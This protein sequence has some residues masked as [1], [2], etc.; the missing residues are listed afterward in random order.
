[1][2]S[3]DPEAFLLLLWSKR[4]FKATIS[5]SLDGQNLAVPVPR[6]EVEQCT[7]AGKVWSR[8]TLE[9]SLVVTCKDCCLHA[10]DPATTVQGR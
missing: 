1:M 9:N 8:S 10:Y 6:D 3:T 7:A 5:Y 2:S 4:Q